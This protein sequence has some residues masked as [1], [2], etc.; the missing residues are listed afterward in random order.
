M[1][2]MKEYSD[3]LKEQIFDEVKKRERNI[4]NVIDGLRDEINENLSNATND[5]KDFA[6]DLVIDLKDFIDFKFKDLRDTM[7]P[8]GPH[9]TQ[10]TYQDSSSE[11]LQQYS[12]YTDDF[13]SVPAEAPSTIFE[14]KMPQE[15]PPQYFHGPLSQGGKSQEVGLSYK[16]AKLIGTFDDMY[17]NENNISPES[18]RLMKVAQDD[19]YHMAG[20]KKL[21]YPMD[22]LE[23]EK[24]AKKLKIQHRKM[25][26]DARGNVSSNHPFPPK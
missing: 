4:L 20:K 17:V 15:A 24:K 7:F 13:H 26:E 10:A 22:E 3:K 9:K 25:Y 6:L 19:T 11:D 5:L 21:V 8:S 23:K 1:K 12:Y 18:V 14:C 2:A 16:P